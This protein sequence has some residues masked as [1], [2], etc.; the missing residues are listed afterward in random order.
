MDVHETDAIDNVADTSADS[1]KV[2][3]NLALQSLDALKQLAGKRRSY[4]DLSRFLKSRLGEV[5]NYT[6]LLGAGCSVSSNV[7]SANALVEIWRREIFTRLCPGIEYLREEAIDFLTKKHGV[8]YNPAKE[9][10]SLFEKNFDLP[11]Q[12]RMFVEQEVSNKAPNL[13]YAYL[14]RLVENHFINTIFTTNFDDLLNE[15]FFRFS[16][17]RPLVCAHD[18][19]VSSIAVTSKR[20]K[21][22]KLHGDYLFDDIKATVRETESLEENSRRKL[23]EFG[24]EFG[25]IVVGYGGGDRSVMDVLQYLLR[26]EDY[27]KHGVYWCIRKGDPLSDDLLK[28]LWRDRVYFVEVDGFDELMAQLYHDLI[29]K[30]LPIDTSSITQKPQAIID[31]FCENEYLQTS[32]SAVITNDLER[33][34]KQR[35]REELL[36]LFRTSK[37]NSRSEG[38]L[39]DSLS[40]AE[41][42]TVLQVKELISAGEY[43]KARV[44]VKSE[45]NIAKAARFREELNGLLIVIEEYSGDINSAVAVVDGMIQDDPNNVANV[46]RKISLTS[47]R[48]DSLRL[49]DK[50]VEYFSEDFVVFNKRIDVN[51]EAYESTPEVE[52]ERLYNKISSDFLR[53]IELEPGPRNYSWSTMASFYGDKNPTFDEAKVRLDSLIEQTASFGKTSLP[54]MSFR[55]ARIKIEESDSPT[56]LEETFWKDIDGAIKRASKADHADMVWFGVE[57]AKDL[58]RLDTLARRVGEAERDT[59]LSSTPEFLRYKGDLQIKLHGDAVGA[60]K[61]FSEALAKSRRASRILELAKCYGFLSDSKAISALLEAHGNVLKPADRLRIEVEKYEAE[62]DYERC[63]AKVRELSDII[64]RDYD[65]IIA[66]THLL[67]LLRRYSDVMAMAKKSL[68]NANWSKASHGPLIINYEL[69]ALRQNQGHNKQRLGEL[70]EYHRSPEVRICAY[71]M[72]RNESRARSLMTEQIKR[73]RENG[74]R[75]GRWAIFSDDHGRSLF[76]GVLRTAGGD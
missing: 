28:L 23:I 36:T 24:R 31:G 52:R 44:R 62:K 16:D 41:L 10:S 57:A 1:P 34:R 37:Q 45:L 13:G 72:L 33:L 69:A 73:D 55:Q 30:D 2:E 39:D 17:T 74:F 11:R 29:G 63:L 25:M 59:S 56:A 64:G 15:A 19:A 20:P 38:G 40:D 18:S 42:A 3:H 7:R 21:I 76:T 32:A 75:F 43:G 68:D 70:A 51:V 4:E 58:W 67:L 27:F 61:L 8:W 35:D 12:R 5:A 47:S 60:A 49:L 65:Q 6:L 66:E 26:S 53:S 46:M 54:H 9:Y 22:I 48:E 71:Y 14:T 50:A